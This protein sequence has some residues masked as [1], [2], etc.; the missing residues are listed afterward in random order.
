MLGAKQL[1][2]DGRPERLTA[3]V[4]GYA[5]GVNNAVRVSVQRQPVSVDC[6]EI[7]QGYPVSVLPTS[8]VKPGQPQPDGTFTGLLPLL[9]GNPQVLVPDSYLA[10]APTSLKQLIGIATAS[11]VSA[12]RAELAVSP[13]GQAAKPAR[14]FLAMELPLEGAKPKVRVSDQKQLQVAGRSATWLDISG[15]SGLSTAEVVS[16]GGQDGVLWHALGPQSGKLDTPFVLNRGDIAV[17][18]ANGPVAWIDSTNPDASKPPGAGESA[19]FEWRRYISWS[20]PALSFGLLV[21]VLV[22]ILALRVTRR[23]NKGNG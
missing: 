13:A 7:P 9:A 10:N 8:H 3:R 4:P 17:I 21:L 1:D 18:A 12:T 23:K 5:L 16:S 20:V 2:A 11:G 19:F 22:L 6:N 14:T 15:L